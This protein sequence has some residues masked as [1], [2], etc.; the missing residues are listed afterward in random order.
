MLH[1]GRR[2]SI[3]GKA[4]SVSYL[5]NASAS[6]TDTITIPAAAAAGDICVLFNSAIGL[7]FASNDDTPSGFT[8][9]GTGTSGSRR[10]SLFYKKL[11][12]GNPGASVTGL[13]DSSSLDILIFR[14][15]KACTAT[16]GDFG[17]QQTDGTPTSQTVTTGSKAAPCIA[18]AFCR[19]NSA[20]T[21]FSTGTLD[22]QFVSTYSRVGYRIHNASPT[23]NTYGINDGG[24]RNALMTG[25]VA[26]T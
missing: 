14:P 6:D 3:T 9:I 10:Y 20:P 22:G 8:K 11:V 13:T 18:L 16:G 21:T 4:L 7:I 17:F 24:T 15:S 2:V 25:W 23:D 19:S 26:L 12:S 1:R 5:T